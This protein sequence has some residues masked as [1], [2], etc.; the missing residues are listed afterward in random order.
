MSISLSIEP[1]R[2]NLPAFDLDHDEREA[3]ETWH[4]QTRV[5]RDAHG[6][7]SR[8]VGRFLNDPATVKASATLTPPTLGEAVIALA[9]HI[10]AMPQLT[11][12]LTSR[13]STRREQIAGAIDP[14]QIGALLALAASTT[15]VAKHNT[16]ECTF[17]RR[18]YPSAGGLLPCEIYVCPATAGFEPRPYRY[19]ARLHALVDYGRPAGDF[20]SVELSG[21]CEAPPCAIVIT[22]VLDRVTRKYGP[23]GYRFAV[24]EAG[25]LGQNIVLAATALGLPSLVYGSYYDRELEQ[26]L[27]LDGLN[28]VV[29]S[30]VL[31]GQGAGAAASSDVNFGGRQS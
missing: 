10:P 20:R 2:F 30:V 26:W 16:I 9:R 25:H 11:E 3:M 29:L 18:S 14:D 8:I 7:R 4:D 1:A 6:R 24:L 22:A 12:I 13:R 21:T 5:S 27:G 19:D 31:V 23:R 28:Q 17:E 15:R